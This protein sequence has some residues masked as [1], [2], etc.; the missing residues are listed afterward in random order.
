MVERD[1]VLAE[2]LNALSA[3]LGRDAAAS[4]KLLDLGIDSLT[5]TMVVARLSDLVGR[6]IPLRYVFN[7][8]SVSEMVDLVVA[9]G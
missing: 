5:A 4:D 7:S 2:A 9:D 3:L 6:D 1:R 8:D